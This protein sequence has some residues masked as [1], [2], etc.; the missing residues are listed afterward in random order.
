M[1][2]ELAGQSVGWTC[3]YQEGRWGKGLA[4]LA[5]APY[6]IVTRE[7]PSRFAV[8][9]IISG[10]ERFRFVGF[11]AM[12]P[13][14]VGYP[15]TR[16]ATRVIEGSPIDDVP[17]VIA[18]DF[19][20]SKSTQ[21]LRNVQRL[22]DRGLVSAYHARHGIRHY[23]DEADPTLASPLAG[24]STLPHGLR[25]RST[26]VAYRFGRGRHVRRLLAARRPERP[27]ARDR[28]GQRR[29][30]APAIRVDLHGED[31]SRAG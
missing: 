27:H 13:K 17:T 25:V 26:D 15:Y 20:A 1:T 21:H 5:R 11:W 31:P 16:Q 6:T 18:G 30:G 23:E 2:P 3:E 12:T 4:V 7:E 22:A 19:N 28:L 9:A 14:D 8:S 10:S 29:V 24:V